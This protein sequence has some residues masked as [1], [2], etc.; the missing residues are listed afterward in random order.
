M[1][2][3]LPLLPL[4]FLTSQLAIGSAVLEVELAGCAA[5]KNDSQRLACFDRVYQQFSRQIS[6][7][8][9]KPESPSHMGKWTV[10]TS[11]SPLTANF[12]IELRLDAENSVKFRTQTVTPVLEL[13]CKDGKSSLAMHWGVYLGKNRTTMLT[14]VDNEEPQQRDW[15]IK[16]KYTVTYQGDGQ[17][18]ISQLKNSANLIARISPY[19]AEPGSATFKLSGLRQQ[20]DAFAISC[21]W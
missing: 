7:I 18:F 5:H 10:N 13:I 9:E 11:P 14:R 17:Q 19:N 12:N 1:K 4:L 21:S 8:S 3:A 15:T 16:D 6:T 2:T 20:L